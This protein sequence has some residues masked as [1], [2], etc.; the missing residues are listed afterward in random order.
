MVV[1]NRRLIEYQ[2][3]NET[4]SNYCKMTIDFTNRCFENSALEKIVFVSLVTKLATSSQE[5]FITNKIELI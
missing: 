5:L 1:L 4:V 3:R 2:S